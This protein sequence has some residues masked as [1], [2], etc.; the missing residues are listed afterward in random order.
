MISSL[1]LCT[2]A[3]MRSDSDTRLL[4]C[5]IPEHTPSHVGAQVFAAD[6]AVG[7]GFDLDAAPLI[8]FGSATEPLIHGAWRDIQR[9]RQISLAVGLEV[10]F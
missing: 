3:R 6:Q 10:S 7:G 8:D 5:G 9:F 4:L 2:M 1:A